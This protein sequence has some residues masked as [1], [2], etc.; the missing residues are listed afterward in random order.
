MEIHLRSFFR[1]TETTPGIERND[2]EA[3]AFRDRSDLTRRARVDP[4]GTLQRADDVA[5]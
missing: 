4:E 5:T 3:L 2:A 1:D